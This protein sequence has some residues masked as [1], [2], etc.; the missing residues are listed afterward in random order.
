MTKPFSQRYGYTSLADVMIREDMP[1]AIQNA[2][3]N[4][5]DKMPDANIPDHD[6]GGYVGIKNALT[7]YLWCNFLNNRAEDLYEKYRYGENIDVFIDTLLDNDYPWYLK[8]DMI[9][10]SLAYLLGVYK[11]NSCC[12]EENPA[13]FEKNLNKEFARLNYAYRIVDHF[14]VEITSDE[15]IKAVEKAID[16]S[17]D[18]VRTHLTNALELMA[19]RP[20]GIYKDSIK[21]SISAVEKWCRKYTGESTLGKALNKLKGK[22][23][24][25]HPKL[26]TALEHLYIYTNQ[27]DTGIRH[28]LMVEDGNYTPSMDEAV[29]MIVTCSAFINYLNKKNTQI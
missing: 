12:F 24:V 7:E 18:N 21:E 13:V 9:E 16:T 26:R 22:N 8:L 23:D 1:E 4:C 15:D 2:I 14:I 10:M 28:A 29:F 3:C 17:D 27:E 19:Q 25:I 11:E 6:V 20:K 5:Y